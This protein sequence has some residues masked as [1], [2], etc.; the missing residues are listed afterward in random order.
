[1]LVCSEWE[2]ATGPGF[3]IRK[4]SKSSLCQFTSISFGEKRVF[5]RSCSKELPGRRSLVR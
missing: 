2:W 5:G 4:E 1:M 3:N